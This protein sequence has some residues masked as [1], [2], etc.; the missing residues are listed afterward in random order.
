MRKAT[1]TLITFVQFTSECKITT[2]VCTPNIWSWYFLFRRI[3]SLVQN[4]QSKFWLQWEP[5]FRLF[6]SY[7]RHQECIKVLHD[8]SYRVIRER[9]QQIKAEQEAKLQKRDINN[10]IIA[11]EDEIG[12]KKRLAFL[13]LCRYLIFGQLESERLTYFC[14]TFYL[15]PDFSDFCLW[16]WLYRNRRRYS[17][18]SR[19][20]CEC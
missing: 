15:F 16:K 5:L 1:E 14:F 13:D 7:K 19:H 17:W 4:R 6:K 2:L 9:K 20:I 8:F 12:T 18:R 3:G 11:M 10:N